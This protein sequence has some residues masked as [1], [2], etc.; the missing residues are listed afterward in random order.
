M[1]KAAINQLFWEGVQ[2]AFEGQDNAYD[3]LHFADD[4]VLSELHYIAD[5]EVLSELHYIN[6]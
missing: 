3:N 5:D 2:G 6:F 1:V 4:E